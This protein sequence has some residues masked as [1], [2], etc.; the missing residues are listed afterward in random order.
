MDTKEQLVGYVKEWI[1]L[2]EEMKQLQSVM[3]E[4]RQKKKELND[5]LVEVMKNNEIECFDIKDGKLL[6]AVNKSKKP[7]TKKMLLET[8]QKFYKNDEEKASELAS[9]IL[10]SR[11]ESVKETIKR[12]KE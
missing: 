12:K 10:E 11:E 3:R 8:L 2:D 5:V 6:Y 4:K 9:F 7:I 1:S